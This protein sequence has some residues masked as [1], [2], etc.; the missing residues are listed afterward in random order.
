MVDILVGLLVMLCVIDSV[1]VGKWCCGYFWG[2]VNVF[3]NFFFCILFIMYLV[4]LFFDCYIVIF[5]LLKYLYVV[6]SKKV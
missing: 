1:V 5:C 4:L 6:I 3:G 2:K